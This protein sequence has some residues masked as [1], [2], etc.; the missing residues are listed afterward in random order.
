MIFNAENIHK[1][2]EP[3]IFE[4]AIAIQEQGKV[5]N[6]SIS[7]D[8]SLIK[9]EVEGSQKTPYRVRIQTTIENKKEVTHA[10]CSCPMSYQCKHI[11]ATLITALAEIALNN[12]PPLQQQVAWLKE[13]TQ[14]SDHKIST[15]S[16]HWLQNLISPA[17]QPIEQ[18]ALRGLTHA[19]L[20]SLSIQP[21]RPQVLT[22]TLLVAKNTKK[23]GHSTVHKIFST[24]TR[25]H[26]QALL[27]IDHDILHTFEILNRLHN[28]RGMNTELY[29]SQYEV[30]PTLAPDLFQKILETN[31]CYWK[32]YCHGNNIFT[33]LHL[34]PTKK[35]I[36]EWQLQDSGEQQLICL[37]D[38]I[39]IQPMPLL[40]L[41]YL[42][43]T[44]GETGMLELTGNTDIS[45]TLLFSPPLHP[46]TVSEVSTG[47]KNNFKKQG[48]P[49]P[50]VFEINTVSLITPKPRL[51]LLGI[52]R[53]YHYF[54]FTHN[55]TT[56]S[57]K[58]PI[59]RLSFLYENTEVPLNGPK[60]IHSLNKETNVLTSASRQFELEGE[61]INHLLKNGVSIL[62]K[63]YPRGI[64]DA[65]IE[66]TD[67]LVGTLGILQTQEA[68]LENTVPALK[69][70]G[71]NIIY[72]PSFP[73]EHIIDSDEWY[74]EFTE[75]SQYNWF[76]ME[77]GVM[78]DNQKIN[79][80]PL[81]VKLIQKDPDAFTESALNHVTD[82]H[83]TITLD[84]HQKI[85]VPTERI[86]SIL[87]TLTELYDGQSL[88]SGRL[89]FN[90]SRISQLAE[91]TRLMESAKMKWLGGEAL[92]ELSKK[93]E[94]FEG[95][96]PVKVPKTFKGTLRDYQKKGVD[97]LNFLREYQL[98]GI[99]AD[100]MGLGKTIQTLA[101]LM[102]EKA[103]KRLDKPCL[104]IA[105]T[106]LMGNWYDEARQFAPSLK[107]ITSQG[108]SR[109]N[110]MTEFSSADVI[111]TTYP[112]IVRDKEILLE[113]E[114]YMIILDEAQFIK[115]SNTKAYLILQKFKAKH[116]LCL[117]GTPMENHLG[118]LWALFN[119]LSPGLLG[120]SKQFTQLFKNPIEKQ[121]NFERRRSLNQ[122][123]RP[124]ILRRTKSEV[125]TELPPKTE[126][127]HHIL[128]EEEQRDLY[129]S[130][131]LAMETKV[132]KAVE[133]KGFS[134]S[135][136]II[137]DALL[138]LR[139]TCADP[140]LLKLEQAKKVTESAKL[141]FLMSMLSELVEEG[142]KI[143]LFSSFTSMLKIIEEELEKQNISYVK[144]TGSTIDRATPIKT[145]Q[146]GE[147]SVFLISL[148]AGG[149]GLN[150]TTADTVIHY[151]PWWNPAAEAQATDRAHRIGQT[152]PVFV[153]KLVTTGTVEEKILLMQQHKR[154]LMESLFEENK[155]TKTGINKEDLKF[156]FQPIE[157]VGE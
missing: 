28:T 30:P 117:T 100:D 42:N 92:I 44:N 29:Q 20:Y 71:W 102:I 58:L 138:K 82:E 43:S 127:V 62:S 124:Y 21:D 10:G 63:V 142:R 55:E 90:R 84:N 57:T 78:V 155:T 38:N 1:F 3:Q 113:H 104:I 101:H 67:F 128:L 49:L 152:K 105:P 132:R 112:L 150:L 45:K 13:I 148:K 51:R 48:I 56:N 126:I 141:T 87:A 131:R 145:F 75:G 147:V 137:L 60:I 120:S 122:R 66:K 37:V 61:Y 125:V 139:Q 80:L 157:R 106:S 99:L 72:D 6:L 140:R 64:L 27:P 22:L 108:H 93:I 153:Y 41:W 2:F 134:Q 144:L 146:A 50:H 31:R 114:Y 54:Y 40:P 133:A 110:L 17:A 151:D 129:E 35:G 25:S 135:Q 156:L 89:S 69:A 4:R 7:E 109:K 119:F 24:N 53:N 46:A 91:L 79:I 86:K 73:V 116:R 68:F 59:A 115:N 14:E 77:M 96:V 47:L 83:L 130:I 5:S 26:L 32:S 52:E 36:L 154:A 23:G 98:G 118:E 33:R 74:T 123:I 70:L 103:S 39:P 121:G 15:H 143:L 18:T 8:G 95:I 107:V 136:I 12:T 88:S 34:A 111:L 11:A 94:H 9:A 76:H 85:R 149:T 65:N 97:W 81:I 16:T 19:I